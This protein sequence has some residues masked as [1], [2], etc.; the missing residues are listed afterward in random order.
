MGD[1]LTSECDWHQTGTPL[2]R[3]PATKPDGRCAPEVS[4]DMSRWRNRAGEPGRQGWHP[5]RISHLASLRRMAICAYP[6]DFARQAPSVARATSEPMPNPHHPRNA[7][8]DRLIFV[9]GLGPAAA[10]V[11]LS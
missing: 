1:T 3:V 2:P 4:L 6:S 11:T 7:D 10:D 9:Q 8:H 5:R